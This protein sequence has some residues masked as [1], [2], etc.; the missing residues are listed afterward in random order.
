MTKHFYPLENLGWMAQRIM[1]S[2]EGSRG[3]SLTGL[4]FVFVCYIWYVVCLDLT[5]FLFLLVRMAS[6][7][8]VALDGLNTISM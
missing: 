5:C 1:D 3:K 7:L 8:T 2:S 6:F 4:V